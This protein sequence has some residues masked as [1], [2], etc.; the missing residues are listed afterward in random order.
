M[1]KPLIISSRTFWDI[2]ISSLNYDDASDWV[3][4]RVFDR[5][6]FE[7]VISVVKYYGKE[8]TKHYFEN[9]NKRLS[10]HSILLAKAIFGLRF[11]DFKCLEKRPFQPT[12]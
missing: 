4:E 12:Y 6:S 7:E 5:G 11:T 1:K 2:D 9:T 8:K 10:N 3:I